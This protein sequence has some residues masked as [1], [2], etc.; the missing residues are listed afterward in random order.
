L[1][2][3][4]VQR[5]IDARLESFEEWNS[6]VA[7]ARR[8]LGL[9]PWT[10]GPGWPITPA[11]LIGLSRALYPGFEISP[12][13]IGPVAVT[14]VAA[15]WGATALSHS[16]NDLPAP[17]HTAAFFDDEPPLI[18]VFACVR[19]HARG[20][21]ETTVA[22]VDRIL[23]ELSP[24]HRRELEDCDLHYLTPKR[25]GRSR[26]RFRAL[27]EVEGLPFIRFRMDYTADRSAALAELDALIDDEDHQ[28]V[29][30]LVAGEV[31]F[32]WNGAPHG[33]RPQI[34][35]TPTDPEERRKLLRCRLRR[36]R[37]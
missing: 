29:A 30:P 17:P 33:R 20:G 37:K 15:Q 12:Y 21:A 6:W 13:D 3:R 19:P 10:V 9:E 5:D 23:E 7:K 2:D 24:G 11:L 31:L 4:S 8:P 35:A 14:E 1:L 28:F 16:Q 36:T 32:L 22:D 26:H 18:A 25:R 27:S 34:G